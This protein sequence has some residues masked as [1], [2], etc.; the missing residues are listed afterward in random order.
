MKKLAIL[1]LVC[2]GIIACKNN[3][4][5]QEQSTAQEENPVKKSSETPILETGCYEFN[6]NGNHVKMEIDQVNTEVTGNLNIAYDGKDTYQGKFVGSLDGDKLFG[7]YTFYAEGTESSREMA[8]L[9][10]DN[11]LIEGY[12]ELNDDG[13]KFKDIS[14]IK[15]TSTMPLT[16]IECDK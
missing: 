10:K 6:N 2:I 7:T 4:N 12:G 9:V 14:T 15:F 1:T 13:T 16:K 8:F 5:T 11:Q 3:T